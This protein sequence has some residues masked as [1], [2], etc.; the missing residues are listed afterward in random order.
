MGGHPSR[1]ASVACE[2]SL[3]SAFLDTNVIIR[4]L[5]GEPPAMAKRATELLA[6]E[7]DLILADLVV[8][9]CVYVL[10]SFYEVERAHVAALLRAAIALPAIRVDDSALLL[11]ALERYEHARLDFAD[12][13]LVASAELTG[14]GA[15][16]SFD[17][18]IDR[19]SSV[20]RIAL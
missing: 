19:I 13:Y 3:L 7:P 14:V 18:A 11:R 4:H 2:G 6:S 9:E 20:E 10:E 16:V 15:V 1:V 12:A 17:K 5:T 8:A